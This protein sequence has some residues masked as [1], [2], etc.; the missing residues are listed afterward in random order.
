MMFQSCGDACEDIK[1]HED[2]EGFDAGV[3]SAEGFVKKCVDDAEYGTCG[4]LGARPCVLD[5]MDECMDRCFCSNEDVVVSFQCISV[6]FTLF[7]AIEL[8]Y[9]GCTFSIISVLSS[10]MGAIE[11]GE[12]AIRYI[13]YGMLMGYTY[14]VPSEER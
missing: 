4:Q 2:G 1:T 11:R 12:E 9:G 10:I 6:S 3:K 13:G 8:L 14:A 7:I 5:G